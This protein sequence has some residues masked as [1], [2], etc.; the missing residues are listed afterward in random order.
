MITRY[1][2]KEDKLDKF[3]PYDPS[4]IVYRIFDRITHSHSFTYYY[5]YEKANKVCEK[6]NN[7]S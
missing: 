3:H 2:V 5:S 1:T 4:L 6:K 7:I